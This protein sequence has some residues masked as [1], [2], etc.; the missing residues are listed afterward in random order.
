MTVYFIGAGPGDPDLITVKGKQLI[1]QCQLVMYTGS[2]VPKKLILAANPCAQIINTAPLCL[3]EIISK[4]QTADKNGWDIA[5]VHTGDPSIYSAIGEQMRALKK[6]GIHY[7]VIPGVTAALAG[8]A[9]LHRELTLPNISQTLIITRYQ[10]NTLVPENFLALARHRATM[11]IYL[12]IHSLENLVSDL[13]P[14]YGPDCPIAVLH[15]IS[16]PNQ[17]V[18]IG[19]LSNIVSRVRDQGFERTALILVGYVIQPPR[20][21]TVSHLYSKEHAD[22]FKQ[23]E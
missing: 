6:I 20:D 9:V 4:I 1:E 17:K 19:I 15:K 21:F 12:S 5:R 8:A 22:L 14:S 7:T 23:K 3:E 2:L 18:V 11:A 13:L 16:Q 10:G